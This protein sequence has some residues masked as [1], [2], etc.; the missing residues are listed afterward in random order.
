MIRIL[1]GMPANVVGVEASG[2]VTDDDYENVLIPAV[3]EKL[4][5]V[6]KIRFIYVL[7]E[8]FEG[9][10]MGALWDDAKVGFGDL[11]AWEKV[12]VVSDKEWLGHM[13]KAFSWM[14]PGEVRVFRLSEF[15]AA[16]DWAGT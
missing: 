2:Q 16:R 13:V 8:E 11:K 1:E 14:M 9:L 3:R 6:G 4:S 10:T 12:A 7:G 5:E 15:D